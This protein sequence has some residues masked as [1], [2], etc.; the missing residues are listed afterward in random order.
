MF[1]KELPSIFMDFQV[2][3]LIHLVDDV[4]FGN[5]QRVFKR[6]LESEFGIVAKNQLE[7]LNAL[8]LEK[9][10]WYHF[11]AIIIVGM[12]FL[13]DSCDLFCNLH[14]HEATGKDLLLRSNQQ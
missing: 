1:E 12:G 10:Q 3:L 2:H 14:R 9:T 5:R 4:E 11:I 7:V 13:T 6:K 8:D